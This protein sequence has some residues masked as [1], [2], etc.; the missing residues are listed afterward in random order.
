MVVQRFYLMSMITWTLLHESLSISRVLVGQIC[1]YPQA[2]E[3][4]YPQVILGFFTPGCFS[5]QVIDEM[6]ISKEW[7]SLNNLKVSIQNIL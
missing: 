7:I 2:S 3:S 4:P 1:F 5:C 6:S